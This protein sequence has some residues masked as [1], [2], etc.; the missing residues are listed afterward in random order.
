[1]NKPRLETVLERIS[2]IKTENQELSE[3]VGNGDAT[4]QD[5]E[6]SDKLLAE[7]GQLDMEAKTI[8][9]RLDRTQNL[10]DHAH[11]LGSEAPQIEVDDSDF[12]ARSREM[13]RIYD[14]D[15]APQTS[16]ELVAR[17]SSAVEFLSSNDTTKEWLTRS[18]EGSADGM[19]AKP[20]QTNSDDELARMVMH[21]THPD[22]VD[23]FSLYLAGRENEQTPAQRAAVSRVQPIQRAMSAGTDGTGGYFVPIHI[24]PGVILSSAGVANPFVMSG[25]VVPTTSDVLRGVASGNASWSWD[26]ENTQVSDDTTT[27]TNTDITT[28][29]AQGYIPI[30]L[31]GMQSIQS[32]P[33]TIQSLLTGGYEDLVNTATTLGT[34]SSQPF[35]IVTAAA[36]FPLL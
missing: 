6:R 19:A 7:F 15:R 22:Y 16:T 2:A 31:A 5:V 32:A 13:D 27:F 11:E 4:E 29:I 25:T 21:S 30:S 23:A 34:G 1:M 8:Q 33:A 10:A 24:D 14:T 36:A 35:G 20:L 26:G 9:T 17:A 18:L 12:V 3:R 28:Y